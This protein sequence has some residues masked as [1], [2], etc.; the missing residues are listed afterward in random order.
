MVQQEATHREPVWRERSD[1][2]IGI[3]IDPGNT[4]V[5]T[6][7]LWARKVSE[8]TFEIC[9]IPFFA[10]D[11]SL[12]DVVEVDASFEV[13]RVV[14][15]SGRYVFRVHVKDSISS[16]AADVVRSIE[17]QGGLVEWSSPRLF[18]VDADNSIKAQEIAN[19]LQQMEE[20]GLLVYETGRTA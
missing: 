11:I 19:L 3:P 6:E 5:I 14:E 12:G 1:F 4:D 13:K 7:Q 2:I 16:V 10:Y 18:A 15:R 8:S 9:C 17:A 20:Q